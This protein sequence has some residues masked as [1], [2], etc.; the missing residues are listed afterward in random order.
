MTLS[1]QA[2]D[3]I[4]RW[5]PKELKFNH[6]DFFKFLLPSQVVGQNVLVPR[7]YVPK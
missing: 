3:E 1:G 4:L 2:L 5:T 6:A 7:G